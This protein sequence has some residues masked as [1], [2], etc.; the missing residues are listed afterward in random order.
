MVTAAPR[1]RIALPA[2]VE[3]RQAGRV[4]RTDTRVAGGDGR[5]AHEHAHRLHTSPGCPGVRPRRDSLSGLRRLAAN[6]ADPDPAIR[7]V[8]RGP[9]GVLL[10][11][12]I[13]DRLVSEVAGFHPHRSACH[14]AS[15]S[16]RALCGDAHRRVRHG[17]APRGPAR[18]SRR[19]ARLV[20]DSRHRRLPDLRSRSCQ[21]ERAAISARSSASRC[22]SFP[23]SRF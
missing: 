13:L 5:S 9:H 1:Y 6:P 7:S 20:A 14:G 16:M 21:S 19:P 23:L 8:G 11:E 4:D 15:G 10:P 12:R 3:P 17:G 22:T 18:C 2:R